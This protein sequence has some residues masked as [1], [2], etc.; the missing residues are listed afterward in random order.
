[1]ENLLRSDAAAIQS[2]KANV[3]RVGERFVDD[4]VVIATQRRA[5]QSAVKHSSL[6]SET[7]NRADWVVE[8]NKVENSVYGDKA[9]ATKHPTFGVQKTSKNG[10][11]KMKEKTSPTAITRSYRRRCTT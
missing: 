4:S 9:K 10:E 7:A 8:C 11:C 6:A 3:F 1:M 2:N 5:I